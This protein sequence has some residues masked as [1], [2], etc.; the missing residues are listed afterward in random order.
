MRTAQEN[1]GP[2]KGRGAWGGGEDGRA[3][4]PART[5]DPPAAALE[6]RLFCFLRLRERKKPNERKGSGQNNTLRMLLDGFIF[7]IL[8]VQGGA[9][10]PPNH[11]K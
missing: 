9:P 7:S 8:R 10:A 3:L 4:E 6:L 5:Q 11:M 1:E 2:R